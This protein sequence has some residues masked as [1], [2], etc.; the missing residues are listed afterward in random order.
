MKCRLPPIL[1]STLLLWAGAAGAAGPCLLSAEELTAATGRPFATG[2]PG[3][4]AAGTPICVYAQTDSPRRRL[5]LGVAGDKART[6]YQAQAR[7]LAREPGSRLD[8]VGEAAYYNG[9]AAGA[10]AG[11]RF[12][13]L[14]QLRRGSD[15]EIAPQRVAELLDKALAR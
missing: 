14:S 13:F 15:P 10:L 11:E 3:Q 6:R 4:D 5:I 7:L 8:G 12:V 9:S 2:E 1:A